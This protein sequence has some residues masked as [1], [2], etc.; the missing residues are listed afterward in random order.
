MTQAPKITREQVVHLASLARLELGETELDSFASQLDDILQTVKAV[1]D[2]ADAA[3][4]Q[5]AGSDKEWQEPWLFGAVN[6]VRAD[7]PLPSLPTEA[8]LAAAPAAQEN[9]FVVP[10]ILGEEP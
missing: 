10:R 4:A 6:V 1:G 5:G 8:A 9:K 2:L 3:E 7:E